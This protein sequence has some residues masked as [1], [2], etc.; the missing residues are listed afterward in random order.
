[1]FKVI[2]EE[3][4]WNTI[5]SSF[6]KKDFY[7]SYDYHQ[8]CI[9]DN[10]VAKLLFYSSGDTSIAFP[11][12]IR[13]INGSGFFDAT[14][15]YGYA[16]PLISHLPSHFDFQDWKE[17]ML[18]YFLGDK[19]I[20]IFSST[21]PFI[22][23]QEQLLSHMGEIESLGDIVYF[24]LMESTGHKKQYSKTTK[25][26]IK[27]NKE[28]FN[29]REGNSEDDARQFL[30]IYYQSM[31]RVGASSQ[32][33]FKLPYFIKL[34]Q[35]NS[36]FDASFVFATSKKNGDVASG[37]F[38]IRT[39]N[40]IVQYHLSGTVDAYRHL[41]PIRGVIDHVRSKNKS[42]KFNFFNLGGGVG[43]K[44]DSLYDFKASFSKKRAPF[45]VWKYISNTEVYDRLCKIAKEKEGKESLNTN[46]FP[47]YRTNSYFDT[48]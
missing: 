16:G 43:S 19:I 21:N 4:E 47:A 36:F 23:D 32:Y 20:S 38:I 25:R 1:M 40:H 8:V 31:E 24:D 42:D 27:R 45:K 5:I 14:S 13:P 12:V 17:Q 44:N 3:N 26:Y 18:G 7:H 35:N 37:A 30:E 41:S 22:D 39:K 11:L 6:E 48:P 10:E 33:Y 2:T 28:L 15:V 34:L 29:I 9:K 46:Y